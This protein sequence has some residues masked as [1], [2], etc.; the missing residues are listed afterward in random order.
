[1]GGICRWSPTQGLSDAQFAEIKRVL[2][3][4]WPVAAG[5]DHSRLLVGYRDDATAPGGGVFSTKDSGV[6]RFD[7]VSYEFVKTRVA[8]AFWVESQREKPK[9]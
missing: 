7:E 4:G 5:S 8:D 9:R 2:A 3:A 6:G 1:M